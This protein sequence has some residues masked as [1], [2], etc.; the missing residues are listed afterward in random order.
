MQDGGRPIFLTWRLHGSLPRSRIF[1]KECMTSGEA[2]VAM[3]RLLDQTVH[4]PQYLRRPDIADGIVK[5]MF[6]HAEVFQRYELNAFVVM[7]NHVHMLFHPDVPLFEITKKLK[8]YTAKVANEILKQ[9]GTPFWQG[10][11]YDRMVRD[12]TEFGRVVRYIENNPVK[13][14][15]VREA[16]E[17]RWSSAGWP[18]R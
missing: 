15:L 8:S 2:F 18:G 7:P 3:D 12:D 6:H 16:S 13:A 5:T 1:T 10:E 14:G 11:S 17:Y 9:T 4:G